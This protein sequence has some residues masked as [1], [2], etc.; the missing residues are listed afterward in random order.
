MEFIHFRDINLNNSETWRGKSILSFDIDWAI[1]PIIDDVVSL[2]DAANIKATFFVTH[3]TKVLN[4]IRANSN[5]ELGI[6]PNFNPL[7]EINPDALSAKETLQDILR[8]V[9]EAKVLRSHGM[10][11]SGRWLSLY[12]ELGIEYLSQYYMGGVDTIQPFSHING[13]V[14]APIFFAD[15]G[16]A[17]ERDLGKYNVEPSFNEKSEF[18]RVF[19]F[20]PIHLKLN[21]PDMS[22]YNRSRAFFT[23]LE[24]LN[25]SVYEGHGVLSLFKQLINCHD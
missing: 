10:T 25:N 17:F 7:I 24:E 3:D 12:K 1:D 9:P 20:H 22:Y 14:E 5:Y 21:T 16:Y 6:H 2:L 8:V 23:N 13:I 4:R 15:D 19:N 11:H 18:L